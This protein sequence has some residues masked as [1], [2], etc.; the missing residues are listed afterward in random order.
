MKSIIVAGK[1]ISLNSTKFALKN[2]FSINSCLGFVS[3][4]FPMAKL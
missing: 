1:I 3:A 2:R 4:N